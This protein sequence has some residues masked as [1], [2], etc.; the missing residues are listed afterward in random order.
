M[1][2]SAGRTPYLTVLHMGKVFISYRRDDTDSVTSRIYDRLAGHFGAGSIFKDAYSISPGLDYRLALEEAIDRCDVLLAVIG[3]R[4]ADPADMTGQHNLGE[5]D[6]V[7]M[8]IERALGRNIRVIPVLIDTASMPRV[9]D[10]P[11]ALAGFAYC[12]ALRVRSGHGFDRDIENLIGVLGEG[13]HE[14]SPARSPRSDA[15]DSLFVYVLAALFPWLHRKLIDKG[16]VRRPPELTVVNNYLN[17]FVEQMER[18]NQVD[19]YVPLGA[20]EGPGATP[21]EA[22]YAPPQT[23]PAIL[24][25]I[26]R[27][28]RLLSGVSAGGDQATAQ[29]AGVNRSSQLVRNVAKLLRRESKPIILLGDPGSG[30]STTLREVGRQIALANLEQAWPEVPIYVPLREYKGFRGGRPERRRKV[31]H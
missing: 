25:A 2:A 27:T 20:I 13:T 11:P 12:H 21:H 29:M 17:F 4:W 6:H 24:K 8:E 3:H 9:A 28:I 14:V 18:L 19:W 5:R 31:H 7:R 30:K 1:S 23:R 10:L 22:E 26:R 16:W 15:G